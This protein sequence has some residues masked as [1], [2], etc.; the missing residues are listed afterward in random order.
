MRREAGVRDAVLPR[1]FRERVVAVV[2]EQ[3]VGA[4]GTFGSGSG[5]GDGDVD[6]QQPIVI[7]VHHRRARAPPVGLDPG[8][9]R[10]V[11]EPLVPF[12]Q[13]QPAG[14][15]VAAEEQVGEA[16]IVD[17]PGG[18][19]RAVIDVDVALNVEGV[20]GRDC[21]G[22]RHAGLSRRKQHQSRRCRFAPAARHGE[23][24]HTDRAA[25]CAKHGQGN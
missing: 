13:V 7:D 10:D 9:L 1:G 23:Q 22:E 21:V 4:V 18:D 25:G 2:D 11:F 8:A 3:E 17:V 16:V 12:V 19:P 14:H 15:H 24:Q 5:T 20:V 6:V